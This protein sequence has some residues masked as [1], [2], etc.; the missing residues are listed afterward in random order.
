MARG[1][2]YAFWRRIKR[3]QSRS[4]WMRHLAGSGAA[5]I[6]SELYGSYRAWCENSGLTAASGK[7]CDIL[8]FFGP[9]ESPTTSSSA[10][11]CIVDIPNASG[12]WWRSAGLGLSGSGGRGALAQFLF[13]LLSHGPLLRIVTLLLIVS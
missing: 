8:G 4:S 10:D 12:L 3:I 11:H 7:G 6:G 5:S 2:D 1:N 13:L 9:R